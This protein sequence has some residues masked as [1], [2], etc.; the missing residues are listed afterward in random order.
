MDEARYPST[1]SY[2]VSLALDF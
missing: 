1:R 2:S